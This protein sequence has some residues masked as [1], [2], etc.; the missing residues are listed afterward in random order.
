MGMRTNEIAKLLDFIQRLPAS[1]ES[2]EV[3]AT[4]M[5]LA[6]DSATLKA[7]RNQSSINIV[8]DDADKTNSI[9]KFYQRELMQ[10]PKTFRKEFRA[11]GC[12]AHV[13]KRKSGKKGYFYE[14]RYRR[15][16]YNISVSSVSLDKAK[17]KFI[18]MIKIAEKVGKK[19]ASP[20]VPSTFHSFATYHFENY[21]KKKVAENT[22]KNDMNRYKK[23]LQ[24]YFEEMPLAKITPAHCQKLL[25]DIGAT[26]RGKTVDEI[27]SL[28]NIIFKAAILH[29]LMQHNPLDVVLHQEHERQHGKALTKEE[30]ERLLGAFK[31]TNFLV[32]FAVALYTGMRPNEYPTARIE[33]EFIVAVNSKR[34]NK[35]VEYK[36]IPITPMLRPYLNELTGPLK[37]PCYKTML[38]KFNAVLPDHILYDMR[39]TFYS[40]CKECGVADAARDEFVG[41]SLG[42]LG[43][44]YTDLSDEFLLREGEKIKY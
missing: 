15:N 16:G 4:V 39:T 12:T 10:M 28:M 9:I 29:G 32:P 36:K 6:A 2:D 35:K 25:E 24:P 11:E 22:Y 8:N 31:K 26:G 27:H 37:F 44:A 7:L 3:A 13:Q 40:R 43:N 42:K 21:R 41:H 14:I 18:E 30:E 33:G 34:K 19:S 5:R 17:Q 20:S 1:P 23:Y 38:D